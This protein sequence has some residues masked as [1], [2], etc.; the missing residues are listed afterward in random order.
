MQ[1]PAEKHLIRSLS[2]LLLKFGEKAGHIPVFLNVGAG[3]S[4]VIEK[5]LSKTG[6]TFLCDRVEIE[7]VSVSGDNL[8]NSYQ[9]SVESMAAVRSGEYDAVFANYMLEHVRYPDKAAAEICRVLKPGGIFVT[10]I[11]NPASP[12]IM[13][14][15]FT[16]LWFHKLITGTDAWETH[17]AFRSIN[18][19]SKIFQEQGMLTSAVFYQSCFE[20]YME[21]FIFLRELAMLYDAF[22]NR[23]KIKGLMNNVCMVFKKA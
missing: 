4:M 3:N 18:G 1:T 7:N 12:E 22:L 14:A 8:R 13:I 17:Y 23:I 5:A 21:R 6:V 2:D 20:S 10:S 19:L 16:P 9:C 15:R 11:P